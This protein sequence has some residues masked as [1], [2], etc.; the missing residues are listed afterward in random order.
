MVYAD[1]WP[2]VE[3]AATRFHRELAT[4][5]TLREI[6]TTNWD[7]FFE[8]KTGAIPIVAPQD[9][10]FWDIPGRHVFKLHGS[11]EIPSTIVATVADYR[12]CYRRLNRGP[13]GASI[14]HLLT[15][16]TVL[17]AGYSFGDEDF[18]RIY[19]F[20]Q[21]ELGAIL[22]SS[23]IVTLDHRI[24]PETHPEATIIHTDATYFVRQLKKLL[25]SEGV[26]MDDARFAFLQGRLDEIG[27]AHHGLQRLRSETSNPAILY[28]YMYQD[29]LKHS[30]ERM[31]RRMS[32]GEYSHSHDVSRLARMYA[33]KSE[34]AVQRGRWTEAA[35][36]EGYTDGLIYLLASDEDRSAAPLYFLFGVSETLKIEDQLRDVLNDART[37]H[38]ELFEYA[39]RRLAEIPP[40]VGP[41]HTPFLL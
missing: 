12:S 34:A 23:F 11:I 33:E 39:E 10:A 9:Y 32:H 16:K 27:E 37:A 25:V 1:A 29:G 31:Q 35:Y 8:R 4:I 14:K 22:P 15:T 7:T 21:R 19:R 18:R 38:P 6:I 2:E 30:F 20:L 24:T 17:F 36:I 26:M 41:H 13:V 28:S 40:G 3:A 5:P